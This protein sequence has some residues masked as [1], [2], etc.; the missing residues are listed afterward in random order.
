VA[1]Y[2]DGE[3]EQANPFAEDEDEKVAVVGECG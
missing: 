1:L 3:E 2:R